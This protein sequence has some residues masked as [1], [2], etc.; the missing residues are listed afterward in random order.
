V[1]AKIKK[2]KELKKKSKQKTNRN[3]CPTNK[4]DFP[5]GVKLSVQT[6]LFQLHQLPAMW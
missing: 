1:G 5:K 2:K 6:F 3:I 4:T